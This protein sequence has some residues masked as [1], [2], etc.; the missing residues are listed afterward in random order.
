MIKDEII[1]YWL[2]SADID[3]QAMESLYKEGHYV[4]TLF[5]GHLVI[6]KLLKAYYVKTVD[7]N[8]LPI[9]HLLKL[10]EQTPL[11]LSEEQ[12][13]YL[14][15][16]TTFNVK[17]RYPDYKFKFHKKATKEFTKRHL[18]AIKELRQWLLDRIKN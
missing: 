6:E 10:A 13:D 7:N 2:D 5:A 18:N 15:E 11:K 12:K 8:P 3:F 1:Q 16:V 17:A 14:L 9:H 4:W